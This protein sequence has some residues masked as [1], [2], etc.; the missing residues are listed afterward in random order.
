MPEGSPGADRSDP[1]P[2]GVFATD[3]GVR[4]IRSCRLCSESDA[5]SSRKRNDAT[6]QKRK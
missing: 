4:P 6:G 5:I 2:L 3:A 1:L